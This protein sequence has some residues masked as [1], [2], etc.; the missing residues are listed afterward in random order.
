MGYFHAVAL[1]NFFN[2]SIILRNILDIKICLILL[3][4]NCHFALYIIQYFFGS[5][6]P[7]YSSCSSQQLQHQSVIQ[8]AVK[9][10][11]VHQQHLGYRTSKLYHGTS[12]DKKFISYHL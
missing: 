2:L 7:L 11:S 12:F 3:K 5:Q 1:D 9:E 8:P 4:L 10:A 6:F